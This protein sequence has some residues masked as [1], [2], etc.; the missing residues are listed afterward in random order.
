M[1]FLRQRAQHMADKALAGAGVLVTRPQHQADE[2]VAAIEAQGGTA[3]RFPTLIIEARPASAI[4]DD[5]AQLVEPDIA[6]FVSPNAVRH[7][8][9][10]AGTATIAAIGPS[11]AAAIDAAGRNV[12]IVS[13]SGYNSEHLLAEPAFK[14]VSG[15][16]VRIIRGQQGRELL[17]DTLRSRGATVDFVAVY[18]RSIPEY[19]AADIAA[20]ET[21]LAADEVDFTTVMSA[22]SLRNLVALLPVSCLD[23]LVE[24]RLVTPAA[25]VIKE[26]LELLP[27]IATTLAQGPQVD[28]MVRA[29][30]EHGSNAPGRTT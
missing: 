15:K 18:D 30:L 19:A 23:H 10:F 27:G 11:T 16:V 8:L 25:R 5:I 7:G 9:D 14:E 6:I 17:A 21:K 3:I 26:A 12:D 4:S 28:D 29:M 2:L 24:T 1:K 20:L 13:A 22:E